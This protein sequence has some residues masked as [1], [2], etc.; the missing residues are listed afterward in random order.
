MEI[1]DY[2]KLLIVTKLVEPIDIS[3]NKVA[4]IRSLLRS[5][6]EE[7]FIQGVFVL[8]VSSMEVMISDVLRYYLIGFP[9]KLSTDFKFEKIEFFKNYFTLLEKIVENHLYKI[10]YESFE[11]YYNRFLKY[12]SIEWSDFH[13]SFGKYLQEI[14]ATRNLLLHNNLVYNDRY[15]ES[16]GIAARENPIVDYDYAINSISIIY[17]FENKLKNYVSEKYKEYT[18]INANKKL[19]QFM[20]QTPLMASY[21]DYWYYDINKDSITALKKCSHESSLASSE[22]MLLE[23]WRSQFNGSPI[24]NLTIRHLDG[25]NREKAM[26]FISIAGDFSFY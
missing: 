22:T 25:I 1:N 26:F 18:K 5:D 10:S 7:V 6:T 21:D 13:D 9:Q 23:L 12:L 4:E 24:K 17:E 20:F 3:M 15:I 16:A 19:W 8:A 11:A 14:K 2:P